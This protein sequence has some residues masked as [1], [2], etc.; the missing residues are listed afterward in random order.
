MSELINNSEVRKQAI[1]DILKKLHEGKSLEEVKEDFNKA[2]SKVS[3][4]EI[5]EA[6]QALIKEGME[7]S[8]IQKLCD[9]HA[10]VFKGSVLEIHKP[11]DVSEVPGHPANVLKLE[12]REIER[13]LEN[14]LKPKK[15]SNLSESDMQDLEG[16]LEEL[17]KIHIHYLKK[18]NLIFPI[19]E[20]KGIEAP[21]KVMWAVDD[22]I[23]A[24][25]K[26]LKLKLQGKTEDLNI[27]KEKL[28]VLYDKIN[29][30]IFKEEN[31]LLPMIIESFSQGDWKAIYE[32]SREIGFIAENIP[33][34][35][36]SL[37]LGSKSQEEKKETK[38]I[39]S[40]PTG[41]FTLKELTA[42]LNTLPFDITF[43]DKEDTVRYFSEGKERIFTRTKA[44]I[45]RKVVNCHPPASVHIVEQIVE[46]LRTGRKDNED[47]WINLGSK[48]AL[49]RYFAVRDEMGEFLGVMEV[50]QDI[51]PIQEITGEKRL[52]SR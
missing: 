16:A 37:Q 50:S 43:V 3:A 17:G 36:P 40:L 27:Y 12:N 26:D 45:G 35:K 47:F 46:D 48:F 28:T 34:W 14:R 9:V 42:V 21:P 25:I 2:F 32:E 52:A 29:E 6:E 4:S 13:I 41:N 1:K 22:E 31:I 18:E 10:A 38:G 19:M 24:L 8:E 7:V 11:K 44:A 51:K 39:I 49:I 33:E 20:K 30:M 23:R 5:S 15:E